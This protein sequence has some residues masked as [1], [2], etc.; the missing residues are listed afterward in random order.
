M[1]VSDAYTGSYLSVERWPEG[2]TRCRIT[3]VGIELDS[4]SNQVDSKVIWIQ[5]DDQPIKYRVNKS[6]ATTLSAAFGEVLEGWVDRWIYL[7]KTRGKVRGQLSW[8]GMMTPDNT[9]GGKKKRKLN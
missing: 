8:I 7:S 9:A 6:N 1:K 3:G 5:L 4:F 2:Q